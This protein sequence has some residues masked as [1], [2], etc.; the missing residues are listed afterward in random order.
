[1]HFELV[2][3]FGAVDLCAPPPE[4]P[5]SAGTA[6]VIAAMTA[7]TARIAR[8]RWFIFL[9]KNTKASP[10]ER[11]FYQLSADRAI[12]SSTL[13]RRF[14]GEGRIVR[15]LRK[16]CTLLSIAEIVPR[17]TSAESTSNGPRVCLSW[18]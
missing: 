10:T 3:A 11:S 17:V 12:F 18:H 15:S 9:L 2:C 4:L 14:T 5:A 6:T 1:M 16:G 13:S 8:V 7:G